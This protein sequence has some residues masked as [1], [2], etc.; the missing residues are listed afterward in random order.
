MKEAIIM[1]NKIFKISFINFHNIISYYF[2]EFYS[3][4][5][6]YNSTHM[7]CLKGKHVNLYYEKHS[8]A[9]KD[10]FQLA[11]NKAAILEHNFCLKD[12][13]LNIYMYD[14]QTT[15]QQKNMVILLHC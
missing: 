11:E 7:S 15:F 9:A 2:I 5:F 10:V 8:D 13:H 3:N 14:S 12:T 1:K 4:I 6:F